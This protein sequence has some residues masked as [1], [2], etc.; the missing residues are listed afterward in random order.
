MCGI[1][2]I[3]Q[4]RN[5]SIDVRAVERA[6]TALSHRGPDDEGY[7]LV[8]TQTK[9]TVLCGGQDTNPELNLPPL[10]K[11]Q[12]E[13][14]DLA[15]GFRRLSILD[16]SPAGHQPMAS[17]DGKCSIIY[18]GEIY[19]YI[20][21]KAELAR[22]GY[23]FRTG[24]DT[25]VILAAYQ[26]WGVDCLSHFNGMWGFAIWDERER[27][28]FLARDRFGIKPLYYVRDNERL[29]FASEIKSLLQYSNVSR[30]INL[31][32]LYEYLRSGLT[33]YGDGTLYENIRQLPA[34]HYLLISI[35]NPETA[36]PTR[37]WQI[38]FKHEIDI[39]F[40][41]AASRLRELFLRSVELHLRSDVRV[42]A[43]LSG[44][45]DSS[46]IVTG[47]RAVAPGLGLHT[48]SYV[49]D[50]PAVSE[51]RW[52][53]I[54][55]AT[56]RAE[57]NKVQ[58]T[59]AELVADLDRLIETQDE[60]FGSTS[61]Y[62]QYRVFRLAHEAGI[63][64]MLDG[65]G[66]DELLGGY[67]LYLAMRMASLLRRGRLVNAG[68]FLRQASTLPNNVGLSGL[69]LV[70]NAGGVLLP[71]RFQMARNMFKRLF[72]NS[73]GA[74][75]TWMDEEWFFKQ[76]VVPRP[77]MK[78]QSRHMLQ[79]QLYETLAESSVPMLLRYEDRNSM[80]HSIES[81]VPFLTADLAE[82]ILAL[83]EEYI[84]AADGTSKSV[85]RQAMRGIVPDAI[86]DRRD[87]IGFATPE[88]RWLATLR[89][90]VEDVLA[91]DTTAQ[92]PGLN[93]SVMKEQAVAMIEG[94]Q[95]FDFRVWRW[96]NVIRWAQKFEV[97]F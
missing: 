21:L 62:A 3:W 69:N 19:N 31:Q 20:E 15:F 9:R 68:R 94:R 65:Q 60:P 11:F 81:R 34:A 13:P 47:M 12:G 74:H 10:E 70:A 85:F 53:D 43:A 78:P 33:D 96:L 6:A 61:I 39:S 64:V 86:L 54:V 55:G 2:G 36:Q 56:A 8:N 90:W 17:A 14:F 5:Q 26:H 88:S 51:E 16:V 42:G 1:S 63:K 72:G 52:V 97:T 29:I 57:V 7:L 35:D 80:A 4:Y 76:G 22:H 66:A 83:P 48:F 92:L 45:I 50:D 28:I 59:P 38:D 44:G 18:N 25:E 93:R 89:P 91:D 46:A 84:I 24:T 87:K 30:Q 37:Y 40:K 67:R 32:R 95:A 71:E 82:F 41:E 77:P 79:E 49:A 58:P 27:R 23:E 75:S 73:N